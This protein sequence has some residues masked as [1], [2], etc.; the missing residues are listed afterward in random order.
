MTKKAESQVYLID[1]DERDIGGELK[2]IHRCESWTR[3]Q[4]LWFKLRPDENPYVAYWLTRDDDGNTTTIDR[5][6]KP[7][8]VQ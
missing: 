6:Q 5:K 1:R 7:I 8:K 3:A 4:N 2:T